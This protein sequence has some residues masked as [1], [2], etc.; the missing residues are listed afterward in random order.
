MPD[1]RSLTFS[2]AWSAADGEWVATTPQFPSLSWLAADPVAALSG[3]VKL[4][5]EVV[6][7]LEGSDPEG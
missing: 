1:T 4:V 5:S 2:V 6:S 7:D 3:L